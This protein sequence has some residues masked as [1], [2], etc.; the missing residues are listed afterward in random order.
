MVWTMSSL[1]TLAPEHG[2][3]REP[4]GP[5]NTAPQL[6]FSQGLLRWNTI[7][8]ATRYE[9]VIRLMDPLTSGLPLLL[10]GMVSGRSRVV[11]RD[12]SSGVRLCCLAAAVESAC[13]AWR[14]LWRG[15]V[16]SRSDPR[17]WKILHVGDRYGARRSGCQVLVK[18]ELASVA[19]LSANEFCSIPI[20][21]RILRKR[22]AIRFSPCRQ[23][24]P[25]RMPM[26]LPPATSVGRLRGQ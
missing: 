25:W 8:G 14:Q 12:G 5:A 18:M 16:G 3:N 26:L 4:E 20:V 15:G 24:W 11:M 2:L 9:V 13:A 1:W 19:V 6:A 7:D 22:F 10:R 21:C 23:Y 17:R